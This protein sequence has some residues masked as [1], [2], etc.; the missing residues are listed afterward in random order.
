VADRAAQ[1]I[2]ERRAASGE[3]RASFC[4]R[5][6]FLDS[7]TDTDGQ[8]GTESSSLF[9][10]GDGH[11]RMGAYS[12]WHIAVTTGNKAC[13]F[14]SFLLFPALFSMFRYSLVMM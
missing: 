5:D 2:I 3:W 8:G 14:S 10:G 12:T 7:D 13:F 6:M 4:T 9:Y 11:G 1:E